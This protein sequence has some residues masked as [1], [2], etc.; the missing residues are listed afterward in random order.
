M[1]SNPVHGGLHARHRQHRRQNS[2]PT[3]YE[4]MKIATNLSNMHQQ[5]HQNQQRS[6]MSHRRGMSLDIRRQQPQQQ[7][8]SPTIPIRQE[9]STVSNATNNTGSIT[10]QHVLR[11]A[12][13][14]R[15]ARPGSQ[16]AYAN[17]ASDDSYL[18]SPHGTPRAQSFEGQGFEGLS[19]QHDMQINLDMYNGPMNVIIKKN[20]ESFSSNITTSQDFDQFPSTLSTPTLMSFQDSPTG[21]PGWISEGETSSTRRSSSRRISNG[22]MDRVSKFENL[23]TEV[24]RPLTPPRQDAT[25]YFP[26]T[27]MDTPHNRTIKHSQPPQRFSDGYDESMEET[28]KPTRQSANGRSRTTFDEMREAAEAQVPMPLPNRSNTM[29][30]LETF[31]PPSDPMAEFL[32]MGRMGGNGLRIDT[33][34][35]GLPMSSHSIGANSDLSGHTTPITPQLGEFNGSFEYKPNMQ[36]P[37]LG[38]DPFNSEDGYSIEASSRRGTPLHRRNESMAS[39][40]SAASIASIDIEKTKMSTGITLEDIHQYIQGPDPR[41]NKWTCTFEDCN[42]KFGRK[43]NIKSHVQTHLN[44]RQYR[45]PTCNKCFVRQ[46]DLKRHAKIHTGIK[47]YPCECGNSFARHDALT[48]H[49]QRGMCIGAFEGVTRKV[50][51]RGRPRKHRPDMN[52]RKEKSVRTLKKNMSTSSMSSQS[53]YSDTSAGNS[54]E[55]VDPDFDVLDGI[56]DVS[57]GGTTMNPNSLQNISSSSAPMPSLGNDAPVSEHS[58]SAASV[59]SYVSQLSHISLHQELLPEAISSPPGSP[60]KSVASQFNE[61]PELSRSSS[62]PSGSRYFDAEPNSSGTEITIGSSVETSSIPSFSGI[63]EADDDMLLQFTN[64]DTGMLML[65]SDSKF[66]EAFDSVDMF[67]NNDDLFFG[68]S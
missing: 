42:K 59:H 64:N 21:G 43:E 41:D 5:Q 45:C 58:P 15:M 34:F 25:D 46:H 33:A 68:S 14:Q 32:D 19:T 6:R 7:M 56:M 57:M 63:S 54:P 50:V 13:Q 2:T 53:G 62:P 55:Y 61:L 38:S 29:P 65:S 17:L 30:L 18:I 37:N 52:E 48:R 24:S 31:N 60:A 49:K 36:H 16:Q 10:S 27:P 35:D 40:A 8:Q 47:P 1:L 44:D 22:I 28:V 67:T 23:G 9:Y 4:T 51:K 26:L 39:I 66:D 3:G 12:Q 11:E 20:Q